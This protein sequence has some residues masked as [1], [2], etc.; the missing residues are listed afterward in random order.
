MSTRFCT[1]STTTTVVTCR[2]A[3][4]VDP[5]LRAHHD[6]L[7]RIE[8]DQEELLELLE[9]AVTWGELDYSAEPVLGP[10]MWLDFALRHRWRDPERVLRIFSLAIDIAARSGSRGAPAVRLPEPAAA[11]AVRLPE[12]AAALAG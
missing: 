9:L 3:G 7:L 8:T 10:P 5:A 12:P 4:D 1:S 2:G 11:P 6:R